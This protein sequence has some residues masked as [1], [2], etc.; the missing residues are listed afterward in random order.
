[1][2]SP[3]LTCVYTLGN[4]AGWAGLAVMGGSPLDVAKG[5]TGMTFTECLKQ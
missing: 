1:M 2:N 3:D 4:G 5:H